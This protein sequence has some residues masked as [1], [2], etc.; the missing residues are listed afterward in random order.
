MTSLKSQAL[1]IGRNEKVKEF[2]KR[3]CSLY[4]KLNK[5]KKKA[6]ASVLNYAVSFQNNRETWKSV[7]L[8][9]DISLEKT[10]CC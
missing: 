3:Y 6:Q 1:R 9:D 5:K 7:S 4:L 8:K 10:F 2:S